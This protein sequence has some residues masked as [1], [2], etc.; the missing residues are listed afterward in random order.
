VVAGVGDGGAVAE[1]FRSMM[2]PP[3]GGA[4]ASSWLVPAPPLA[5]KGVKTSGVEVTVPWVC[6]KAL[7]P[8]V[9][10]ILMSALL[11]THCAPSPPP[12]EPSGLGG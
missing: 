11:P 4:E 2:A 3:W 7:L 1:I 8:V 9:K 10:P 6:M 5:G 12:S